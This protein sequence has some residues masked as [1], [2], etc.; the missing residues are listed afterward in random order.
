MPPDQAASVQMTCT[1]DANCLASFYSEVWGFLSSWLC[2]ALSFT[3][4][5]QI[6]KGDYAG[7][8]SLPPLLCK[9]LL[10][11]VLQHSHLFSAIYIALNSFGPH[12]H[13]TILSL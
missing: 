11:G 1:C 7:C 5:R 6:Y 9:Q 8:G 10:Q 13:L 3:T 4:W 2:P 12:P